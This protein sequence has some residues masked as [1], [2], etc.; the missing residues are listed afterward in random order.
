MATT[1][2]NERPRDNRARP[3]SR[4]RRAIA[5]HA[6]SIATFSTTFIGHQGWLVRSG[7]SA[8]LVD[9]VLCEDFGEAYALDY[10]VYPPRE[11]DLAA[12]PPIDAL[13]L[14]HEH[15]DH[16]DIPSLAR[17]D[18]RIPVWLSAHS[19]TAATQILREMG[20]VVRPLVPG[21]PIIV[22]DLEV[23]P[24]SG[25]HLSVNCDDEWDALPFLI[26][27]R[28]GH[29]SLF[30]MVDIMMVPG[31]LDW[32][33]SCVPQPGLVTWTNNTLDWSHTAED[34]TAV[35][36]HD[37]STEQCAE[38]MHDGWQKVASRW[39][40]P[41]AMLMCA[42]GFTFHGE[43]SWLN[44]RVF[45]IDVEGVCG[46]LNQ[47]HRGDRFVCTRPG[48]TFWMEHNRLVRVD[49]RTPFLGTPPRPRW[50][51]RRRDPAMTV[52]DYPPATG[53]RAL[54]A[55]DAAALPGVLDELA[56]ALVGGILFRSLHSLLTAMIGPRRP[57]FALVLR[58]DDGDRTFEYD[59]NGCA[60]VPAPPGDPRAI[61]LAGMEC[62]ASDF[63]AVMRGAYGPITLAYGRAKVW[64]ALPGGFRFDLFEA[65]YRSSHP[66]R[67]PKAFLA[68]YRR[69]W[70]KHQAAMPAVA[71]AA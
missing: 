62:W 60:F 45:G 57:T 41:A 30:S 25:D 11:I 50:P 37:A 32:A 22:G 27:D 26:R 8:I 53:R 6:R 70:E 38:R 56:G 58:S 28:A 7:R 24:F 52:P 33:R 44:D 21:A 20:F 34:L 14:T 17:L 5:C 61:Y 13:V 19:S 39:G 15:D 36:A 23:V 2:S 29:G 63:V 64:N 71:A 40:E 1:R 68:T 54:S 69:L 66:L 10:R 55:D 16:F 31:H 48:Q 43:R 18:R 12:F 4:S 3:P 49:D 59:A 35:A 65:L 51:L 42:G 46:M 47:R 9:P 67:R